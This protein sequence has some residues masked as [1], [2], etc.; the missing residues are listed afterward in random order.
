MSRA[1]VLTGSLWLAALTW[2]ALQ[3]AGPQASAQPPGTPASQ[4]A[5]SAAQ[6]VGTR[7]SG[8]PPAAQAHQQV[9][10]RYCVTCH[11]QRLQTGGLSLDAMDWQSIPNG[12]EVWEKVV[13]K[14]RTGAMPPQ[15]VPRPAGTG[16]DEL[17]T[18][19][20]T[21]LDKAAAAQ[22]HPGPPLVRRLNRTEYAAAVRDLL[23]LD[24]DA[25]ALFPPDD[26]AYGFDNISDALKVSPALQERYLSAAEKISGLAVGEPGIPAVSESY[27]VR[28]DVSQNQHLE[29]LPLGTVGGM[30]VRHTFPLDGEYTFHVEIFRT[31]FDNAKGIEHPHEFEITVDGER[32]HETTIGGNADLAAAFETPKETADAI[33]ARMGAR[34]KVTAGPH[35]VVAAFIGNLPGADTTRL[36]PFLKSAFD[37]LDWTGRPAVRML[38]ITGP[39]NA[40]SAGET[41]SRRRIFT[42]HPAAGA[43]QADET[44]CARQILSTL[45]RRGYRQPVTDQDLA[46]LMKLYAEGRRERGFEGGIQA[47]LQLVLASPRFAFRIERDPDGIAP[48]RAYRVSD[49]ELASRLSFFLWSSLPDDEL[50][51]A[52]ARGRLGTPAGL[53]QQVRRMLADSRSQALVSNFAGQW[54]HLRNVRNVQPHSDTFPDFD[55][56]LRQAFAREAELFFGSI[57]REDRS[58]LDLMTANHT[59]V[60]ERLARHYGIPNVYGS[61]F[62]RITLADESRYGLLGKGGILSLTSVATRTSPVLRG[63]WILENVLGTPPAPPPPDVPALKENEK[64][65]KPKTVREQMAEHRANP[66]CASCHKVMDPLGFA[67]ENFDAVGGWRSEDH[68][69]AIDASAELADGTKVAG[70]VDLR[71]ALVKRPEVFAGTV[72]EKLL[73]YALGRGLDHHDMPVVRGIVRDAAGSGYRFSSIVLGVARSVPF[74]MR[75]KPVE[76]ERRA[77]SEPKGGSRRAGLLD[78]P[79]DPKT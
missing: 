20:E 74:Q 53:E 41:P 78:P 22:P 70:V 54:L 33:D 14:L 59:F 63:K 37:T 35:D 56:N 79:G 18:W 40:A 38:T 69:T 31:N 34:V 45:A 60:N 5:V 46:P 65:A 3:A 71:R 2:G 50:L 55:D 66:V 11:N 6:P 58:V 28:G 15:G 76:G 7:P 61:H 13:R 26:S 29:G 8:V 30:R 52:A 75:V 23:A 4:T 47:A 25:T 32:V 39:F 72:T 21:E 49:V 10:T 57:V 42:C 73:T 43:S 44:A 64:G 27:R 16:I 51:D 9:V 12:A 48:G 67:L 62:R 24:V 1:L 77:G 17:A 36:R 19:V 68:G